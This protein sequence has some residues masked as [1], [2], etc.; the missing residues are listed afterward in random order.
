MPLITRNPDPYDGF[1]NDR[2]R[3]Q[4]LKHRRFWSSI[5]SIVWA[6][7]SSPVILLA[8]TWAATWLRQ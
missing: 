7:A 4:A 8:A 1:K 3:L 6:L 2:L 5:V